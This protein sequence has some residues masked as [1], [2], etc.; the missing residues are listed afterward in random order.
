MKRFLPLIILLLLIGSAYAVNCPRREDMEVV[1]HKVEPEL[2]W[3]KVKPYMGC[4]PFGVI[5]YTTAGV[6][7]VES[8]DWAVS[9]N[10]RIIAWHLANYSGTT[11]NASEAHSLVPQ[12]FGNWT[13]VLYYANNSPITIYG[14]N[15]PA[16][17]V[18]HCKGLNCLNRIAERVLSLIWSI[19]RKGS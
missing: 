10:K 14:E 11:D 18:T 16:S 15:V 3:L 6:H 12:E 13:K 2:E 17:P 19:F 1:I 8:E 5:A 9:N 4:G 7:F